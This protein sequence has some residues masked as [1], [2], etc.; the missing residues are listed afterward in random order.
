MLKVDFFNQDRECLFFLA[1]IA[2][3]LSKNNNMKIILILNNI[4]GYIL[5]IIEDAEIMYDNID[6]LITTIDLYVESEDHH[7]LDVTIHLH[8]FSL[9]MII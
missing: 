1:H 7:F 9:K 2:Y 5:K 3:E 8:L 6:N 4:P